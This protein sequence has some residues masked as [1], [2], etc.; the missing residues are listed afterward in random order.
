MFFHGVGENANHDITSK[1]DVMEKHPPRLGSR[2]MACPSGFKNR[3]QCWIRQEKEKIPL[4]GCWVFWFVFLLGPWSSRG[5]HNV[6]FKGTKGRPIRGNSQMR[7]QAI[8]NR[9]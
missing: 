2:I 1:E 3:S 6:S 4:G 8:A 5:R 9:P 7:L